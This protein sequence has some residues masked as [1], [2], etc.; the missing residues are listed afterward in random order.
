MAQLSA[1]RWMEASALGLI[2][3]AAAALSLSGY[4]LRYAC[5]IM[6]PLPT[7]PVEVNAAS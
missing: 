6:P 7:L 5:I 2:L 3:L 1:A 4:L